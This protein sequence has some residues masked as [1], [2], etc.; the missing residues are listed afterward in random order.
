LTWAIREWWKG[1]KQNQFYQIQVLVDPIG[2]VIYVS[3]PIGSTSEPNYLLIGDYSEGLSPDKIKWCPWKLTAN[4]KSLL[5]D[6]DTSTEV[7]KFYVGHTSGTFDSYS[8]GVFEDQGGVAIDAYGK[9]AL[10]SASKY[11][12]VCHF[13]GARV[14]SVGSGDL[15]LTYYAE[16]DAYNEVLPTI[17]LTTAPGV[18]PDTLAN[19]SSVRASLKVRTNTAGYWFSIT[20]IK[21]FANILWDSLPFS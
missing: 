9:T 6:I 14:Q 7:V 12:Q 19:F 15:S 1:I 8:P 5:L 17:A 16:Q 18:E 10:V 11:G 2:Q 3:V 4:P 21:I 13:N 20:R